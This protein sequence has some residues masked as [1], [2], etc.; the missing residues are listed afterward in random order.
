M[1]KEVFTVLSGWNYSLGSTNLSFK[2][3][4]RDS[5]E[6]LNEQVANEHT[7]LLI[8]ELNVEIIRTALGTYDGRKS[9]INRVT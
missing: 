9:W 4:G 5:Y 8:A 3:K 1:S 2:P 6:K 7:F